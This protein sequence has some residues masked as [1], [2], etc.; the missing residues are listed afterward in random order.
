VEAFAGLVALIEKKGFQTSLR[1]FAAFQQKNPAASFTIA[2]EG[3]MEEQ[4]RSLARELGVRRAG[5]VHRLSFPGEA[6]RGIFPV[7]YFPA[8]ERTRLAT[9]TRKGFRTRC[10]KRWRVDCL[11]SRQRHGGIPE[12]IDDGMSGVL[13]DER[14]HAALAEALLGWTRRPG[15]LSEI[16]QNAAATVARNLS[17]KRRRGSWRIFIS[18]RIGG[19]L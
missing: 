4:L 11:S 13:V 2:G 12:A 17:E 3:P 9:G 16:G 5:E 14:D 6:A 15:E 10:S 19:A 8:S 18:K 7:A 1:A